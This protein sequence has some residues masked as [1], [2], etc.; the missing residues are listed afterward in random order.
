MM[1]FNLA[2][3]N[4]WTINKDHSDIQFKID[5]LNLSEVTG[6][7]KIFEG[8]LI[9]D[10]QEKPAE[11]K[12]KIKS[13]SIDTGNSLRDS[14]LKRSDFFDVKIFPY[15]IFTSNHI[16]KLGL[17]DYRA[18]GTLTIKNIS[19]AIIVD[20]TIS[21][22]IKDTWN[23]ESKFVSFKTKFLRSDYQ[24]SWNKTLPNNTLLI[25]DEITSW[26]NIQI[27]PVSHKTPTSKHLI[28]LTPYLN[29]RELVSSGKMDQ[30]SFDEK[31]KVTD[32]Q[33]LPITTDEA[34]S[35]VLN[36]NNNQG[37]EIPTANRD[38]KNLLWWS[39]YF[40]IGFIGFLA[41]IIVS[42]YAK[43]TLSNY[44]KRNYTEHGIYGYLSDLV[45]IFLA[46]LFSAALY[47]LTG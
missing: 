23:Y 46:L 15:V 19:Q 42:F 9:F 32:F 40:F 28:P 1:S 29:D 33:N 25:G 13:T 37:I 35:I 2:L 16:T 17:N 26:G 39:A 7:F 4:S 45:V 44:F 38:E 27:Q 41:L 36:Q 43:S 34:N 18:N 8:T 5:Y 12:L 20:F 21:Q 47:I 3:G 22:S 10:Q 6:K 14:H 24:I 31:Y 30:K 11:L